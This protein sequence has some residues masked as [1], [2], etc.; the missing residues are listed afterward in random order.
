MALREYNFFGP[1]V[2]QEC[3]ERAER[4]VGKLLSQKNENFRQLTPK[5]QAAKLA[6]NHNY[7]HEIS[8]K[9]AVE[10]DSLRQTNIR[11][12]F[13]LLAKEFKLYDESTASYLDI[14]IVDSL[15]Y[16]S[17]VQFRNK[18]AGKAKPRFAVEG[19]KA[20]AEFV[21]WEQAVSLHKGKVTEAELLG[22]VPIDDKIATLSDVTSGREGKEA[23]AKAVELD[24]QDKLVAKQEKELIRL[25]AENTSLKGRVPV[26]SVSSTLQ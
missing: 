15:T 14:A 21:V 20:N 5:R 10:M 11:Y 26:E 16:L 23:L 9:E 25:Q 4:I 6:A 8:Y 12:F 1:V 3:L 13:R 7:Q 22:S 18:N 2:P 17:N 24:A 19:S